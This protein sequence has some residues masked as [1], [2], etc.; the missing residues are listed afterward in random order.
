MTAPQEPLTASTQ[1]SASEAP[2][3]R[4]VQVRVTFVRLPRPSTS[5]AE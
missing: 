5:T 4:P 2:S 3:K 1:T